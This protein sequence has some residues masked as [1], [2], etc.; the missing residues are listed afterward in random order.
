MSKKTRALLL[1]PT[2]T[3]FMLLSNTIFFQRG[4]VLG[5]V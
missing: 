4:G 5:K 2:L 3:T 1:T